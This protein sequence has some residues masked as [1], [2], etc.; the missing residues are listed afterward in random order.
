MR[1]PGA[2]VLLLPYHA[3]RRERPGR[4]HADPPI[5]SV[6]GYLVAISAGVHIWIFWACP[7]RAQICLVLLYRT[8]LE[9][10]GSFTVNEQFVTMPYADA[11]HRRA[12][13]TLFTDFKDSPPARR[14]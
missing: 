6:A 4:K 13:T 10:A 7:I 14:V 2:S 9:R 11:C 3:E 8:R 1:P 5:C 12:V